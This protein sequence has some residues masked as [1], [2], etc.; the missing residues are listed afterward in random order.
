M[1]LI[2]LFNK[3]PLNTSKQLNF[4][5][6]QKAYYLYI[7]LKDKNL[8]I[9]E[10]EK[11]KAQVLNLKAGMNSSRIFTGESASHEIK[12]TP[13]WLLGFIE[14]EGSFHI[15]TNSFQQTFSIELT[16]SEKPVIEAIAQFLKGL[17]PNELNH[18]LEKE[19]LIGIFE[20]TRPSTSPAKKGSVRV[21][22][23][24]F[25]FISQV[26]SPFLER[27]TFFSKKELDFKDWLLVTQLKLKGIHLTLEGK[28]F[29][30]YICNRMNIN[31][32]STNL[33]SN[34]TLSDENQEEMN[35]KTRI[36]NKK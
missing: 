11:I 32:L 20:R 4:S 31:R 16:I 3:H 36:T 7:N 28:E 34:N 35:K 1:E 23:S 33:N 29:I 12:V 21:Y 6:W 18:L 24:K 14:G 26:F 13:Y 9:E 2:E 5:D 17:I 19:N 27:L 30:K 8:N 10:K 15:D 22:F 25:A